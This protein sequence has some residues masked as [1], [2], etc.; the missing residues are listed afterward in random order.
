M[1]PKNSSHP[2]RL[3]PLTRKNIRNDQ[4]SSDITQFSARFI[5]DV[6]PR[7]TV[8]ISA[9]TRGCLTARERIVTGTC[10]ALASAGGHG[11][12]EICS[13]GALQPLACRRSESLGV[14]TSVNQ[15]EWLYA[16]RF[17]GKILESSP[18]ARGPLLLTHLRLRAPL[19]HAIDNLFR[20]F[21]ILLFGVLQDHLGLIR[22]LLFR[23]WRLRGWAGDQPQWGRGEDSKSDVHRNLRTQSQYVTGLQGQYLT[24]EF[25]Y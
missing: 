18:A 24:S 15:I 3:T 2:K 5:I 17:F 12:C 10:H 22:S 19:L 11:P 13:R 14:S 20:S 16:S 23:L 4:P 9:T 25:G 1:R 6:P 8:T 21:R 7:S